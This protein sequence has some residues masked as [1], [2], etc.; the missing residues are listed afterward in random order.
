M[1]SSS[2]TLHLVQDPFE[3]YVI[4]FL[5]DMP[6]DA[7]VAASHSTASLANRIIRQV[8]HQRRHLQRE[9]PGPNGEDRVQAQVPH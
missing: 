5:L 3:N 7:A 9:G 1:P 8:L 2:K 6:L 4:Q